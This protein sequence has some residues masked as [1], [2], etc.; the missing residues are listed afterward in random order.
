M[1]ETALGAVVRLPDQS[2]DTYAGYLTG[3][4][5][6]HVV[7][8]APSAEQLLMGKMQNPIGATHRGY[9]LLKLNELDRIHDWADNLCRWFDWLPDGAVIAA[10]TAGRRG[11]DDHA[12]ELALTAVG[13]GIP[14]FSEGLSI[15]RQ[16]DPPAAAR[17]RPCR[18]CAGEA[19]GRLPS[20]CSSLCPT[21][22]FGALATHP[23]HRS[24]PR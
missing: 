14:L 1:S 17:R 20:R 11:E 24:G 22:E 8:L 12:Y 23:A 19:A 10:E 21:A 2:M 15:T 6:D 16:P 3:G 18:R 9:A 5:P 4:R 13:R 7:Q